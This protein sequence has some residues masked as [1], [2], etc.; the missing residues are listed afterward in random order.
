MGEILGLGMTHFPPLCGTDKDM[1]RIL[2]RV[3]KDPGLPE[4]Y[5]DPASWPAAMRQEYGTD[6]GRAAA[7]QHLRMEVGAF[8]TSTGPRDDAAVTFWRLAKVDQGVEVG[9]DAVDVLDEMLDPALAAVAA[10]ILVNG[11]G[12]LLRGRAYRR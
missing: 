1:G 3:L 4:Q 11:D 5:R 6:S 8:G 7:P 12:R 2:D 10:G 9:V